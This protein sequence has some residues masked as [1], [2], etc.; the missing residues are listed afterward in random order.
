MTPARRARLAHILRLGI[1][2]GFKPDEHAEGVREQIGR[3][4][5]GELRLEELRL[6]SGDMGEI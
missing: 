5:A 4:A 2:F 3:G 6:L 1:G